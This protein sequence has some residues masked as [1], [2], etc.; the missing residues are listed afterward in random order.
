MSN[1]AR[2]ESHSVRKSSA[3]AREAHRVERRC[4]RRRCT[5]LNAVLESPASD[6]VIVAMNSGSYADD[7]AGER[8]AEHENCCVLLGFSTRLMKSLSPPTMT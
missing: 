4:A 8:P 1:K 6:E 7:Q 5:L 3:E 2:R